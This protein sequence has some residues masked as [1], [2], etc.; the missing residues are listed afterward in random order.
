MESNQDFEIVLDVI[1]K[2]MTK[3]LNTVYGQTGGHVGSQAWI[4]LRGRIVDRTGNPIWSK[5][6]DHLEEVLDGA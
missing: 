5:L 4:R 2:R 1:W 3:V 6:R